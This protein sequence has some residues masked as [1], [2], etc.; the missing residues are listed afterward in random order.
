[1]KEEQYGKQRTD[2]SEKSCTTQEGRRGR[3]KQIQ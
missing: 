2:K 1:M 3:G